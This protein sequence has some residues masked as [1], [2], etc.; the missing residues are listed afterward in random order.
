[1]YE[2]I[3]NIYKFVF[4]LRLRIKLMPEKEFLS[5][6]ETLDFDTAIYVLLFRYL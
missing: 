6:I 4:M 2:A 5:L 1:M 3:W